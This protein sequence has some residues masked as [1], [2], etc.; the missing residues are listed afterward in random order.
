M[1]DITLITIW[2]FVSMLARGFGVDGVTYQA[3]QIMFA[4][5]YV[6][7]WYRNK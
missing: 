2:L 4:V 6:L 7:N 1:N 3:F 5:V